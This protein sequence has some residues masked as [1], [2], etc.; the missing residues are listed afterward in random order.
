M[1][2]DPLGDIKPCW[3]VKRKLERLPVP[4][5]LQARARWHEQQKQSSKRKQSSRMIAATRK[6]RSTTSASR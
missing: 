1:T 5:I 6:R 4:E 3:L 2:V